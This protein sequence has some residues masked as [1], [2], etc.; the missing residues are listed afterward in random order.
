MCRGGLKCL[1]VCYECLCGLGSVVVIGWF[2]FATV[3]VAIQVQCGHVV[4]LTV[5]VVSCFRLLW[6]ALVVVGL[7]AFW[8]VAGE[9]ELGVGVSGWVEISCGVL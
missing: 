4:R 5:F 9:L 3:G 1:V 7:F 8:C 6:F 2:V